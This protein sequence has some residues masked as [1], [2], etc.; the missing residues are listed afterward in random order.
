M[1]L[2]ELKR[3]YLGDAV[4]IGPWFDGEGSFLG[5]VIT[6]ENGVEAYATIYLEPEVSVNLVKYIER[7]VKDD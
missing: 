4:Y 1:K 5:L 2:V 7:M 3:E 6:A